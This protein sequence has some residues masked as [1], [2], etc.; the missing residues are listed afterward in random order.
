MVT[1]VLCCPLEV[2]HVD[3]VLQSAL[4]RHCT[5]IPGL[6]DKSVTQ[7]M[8]HTEADQPR[9]MDIKQWNDKLQLVL[10]ENL[11]VTGVILAP[12][13]MAHSVKPAALIQRNSTPRLETLGTRAVSL[14]SLIRAKMPKAVCPLM[15]P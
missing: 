10:Q 5:A 13:K 11:P 3:C 8:Q 14:M 12:N 15:A 7:A 2:V 9:K 1:H 6:Q 4:L